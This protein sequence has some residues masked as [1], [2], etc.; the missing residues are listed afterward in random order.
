MDAPT[1]APLADALDAAL[2]QM[3]CRRCGYAGCRPYAEAVARGDAINRCPPGGPAVVASLA[4]LTAR[5]VV[6]LDP[7]HGRHAPLTVARI[8][9]A[10]C[11]G[12]TL[13]LAAC[14]VDA[15]VGAAKRMHTVLAALCSGCDLCVAPCPVDCIAMVPA[16]RDWTG[17]DARAARRRFD[18]RARR[19]A[20]RTDAEAGAG[21]GTARGN[22][23][24]AADPD[25][26]ARQQAVAAALVRARARRAAGPVRK[27]SV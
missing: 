3:Q 25:R 6:P 1:D 4:G 24:A 13:C 22:A 26:A 17:D 16:G 21:L 7:A 5:L 12:C 10:L 14:P 27:D 23:G 18:A 8:D 2:P 11:I 20:D 15:I 19:L 9:E